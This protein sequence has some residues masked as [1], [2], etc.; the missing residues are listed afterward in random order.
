MHEKLAKLAS[1][2]GVE[3]GYEDVFGKWQAASEEA[4]RAVLGSMGVDA[5]TDAAID[6]AIAAAD[7]DKHA[8]VVAPAVV[9]R[10]AKLEAGIPIH[11]PERALARTLSWRISEEEGGLREDASIRCTS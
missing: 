4:L 11:L 8:R 9:I 3:P 5:S 2:H 1:L 10:A 6:V 7:R